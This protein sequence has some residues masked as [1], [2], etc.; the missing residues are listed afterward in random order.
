MSVEQVN[1]KTGDDANLNAN[2]QAIKDRAKNTSVEEV[3]K[4]KICPSCGSKMKKDKQKSEKKDKAKG[5]KA[6]IFTCENNKC[7]Y[8]DDLPLV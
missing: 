8:S 2:E 4:N 1:S 7:G 5:E 3:E 6:Y